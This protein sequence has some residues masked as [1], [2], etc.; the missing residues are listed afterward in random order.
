MTGPWLAAAAALALFLTFAV[1]FAWRS[2]RN[3]S[4]ALRGS[5]ALYELTLTG[6][7]GE[8]IPLAQFRG[9][10][11]LVVNTASR[12]G[13]TQQ[14]AA[15]QELYERYQAR[16]LRILAV[17]SN[18]FGGQEP[19][20]CEGILRFMREH[21]RVTFPM[22][23]KQT[24]KGAKAHP[25]F[26]WLD[27]KLGFLARPRWNFYKYLVSPEGIPVAW[28]PSTTAPMDAKFIRAIEAHLPTA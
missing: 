5:S 17:P 1:L 19:E 2:S 20:D 21:F 14:Y 18:D 7:T 6:L 16:G 26:R 27:G 15:L 11:L 28:F 4:S 25:L 9:K 13:F 23:D 10:L 3:K 8:P 12:C 24:V 22:T